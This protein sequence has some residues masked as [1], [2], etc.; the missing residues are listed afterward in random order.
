MCFSSL[1]LSR[2]TNILKKSATNLKIGPQQ[3]QPPPVWLGL[4]RNSPNIKASCPLELP[5]KLLCGARMRPSPRGSI[6][7]IFVPL[8]LSRRAKVSKN[9]PKTSKSALSSLTH[10]SL[11]PTQAG[12]LHIK[13]NKLNDI[14]GFQ[15][16]TCNTCN[17][18]A[19]AFA[20]LMAAGLP[21]IAVVVVAGVAGAAGPWAGIIQTSLN[22]TDFAGFCWI[23]QTCVWLDSA[24]FCWI[25]LTYTNRKNT[26]TVAW[27]SP[28]LARAGFSQI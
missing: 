3:A 19:H 7:D 15:D 21:G 27:P 20:A 13:K 9:V 6:L 28:G 5:P 24:G 1:V 22:N 25:M 18:Q 10:P 8:V 11:L 2:R 26:K 12:D 14:E 23:I 17:P 4:D 16:L